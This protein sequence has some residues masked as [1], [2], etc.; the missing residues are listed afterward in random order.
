MQSCVWK[1][2][3]FTGSI[4]SNVD[5]DIVLGNRL[6]SGT[7]PIEI[8][9]PNLYEDSDS[10]HLTLT[11]PTITYSIDNGSTFLNPLSSPASSVTNTR[12]TFAINLPS[13][14]PAS[15]RLK[16]RLTGIVNPPTQN[17]SGRFFNVSTFDSSNRV[18][19]RITQCTIDP[20]SVLELTGVFDRT[21]L[22]VDDAYPIPKIT[23]DS[24]IPFPIFQGDSLQLDH[25]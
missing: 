9:F 21:T 15:S 6:L 8:R 12:I 23:I 4:N 11:S 24:V 19:D 25:N 7:S 17:P 16:I 22:K 3:K 1:F 5:I 20:I 10:K 18:I 2:D 14:L 13:G